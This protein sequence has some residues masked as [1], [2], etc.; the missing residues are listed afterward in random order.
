M[1]TYLDIGSAPNPA[2]CVA[3]TPSTKATPN[4]P[5]CATL[6]GGSAADRAQYGQD[7]T[8]ECASDHV[9]AG[10]LNTLVCKRWWWIGDAARGA[11]GCPP[12]A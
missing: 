2:R 1:L 3:P 6:A 7:Q 4:N 10:M 11:L 5:T 12:I 9:A 8:G